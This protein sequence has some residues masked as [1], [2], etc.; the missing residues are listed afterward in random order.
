MLVSGSR[1]TNIILWSFDGREIRRLR[2]HTREIR[3]LAFDPVGRTLLSGAE[4]HSLRLWHVASGQMLHEF[5]GHGARVR[6]VAISHDGRLAASSSDD[7]NIIIWGL[8]GSSQEE[9]LP[10]I[11][12]RRYIRSLS[13]SERF[14]FTEPRTW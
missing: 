10:A 2:N 4:D 7:G 12:E 3:A 14:D 13:P 9:V 1:D 11:R 5:Q 8:I 6:S